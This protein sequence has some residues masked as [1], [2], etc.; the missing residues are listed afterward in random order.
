VLLFIL[1]N[2]VI[3]DA[4]LIILVSEYQSWQVLVLFVLFL[5][6]EIRVSLCIPAWLS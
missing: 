1:W 2:V 3:V 6:F 5:F 4:F